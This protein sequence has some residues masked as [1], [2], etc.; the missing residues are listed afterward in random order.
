MTAA[1]TSDGPVRGGVPTLAES[2][3]TLPAHFAAALD[4]RIV[5]IGTGVLEQLGRVLDDLLGYAPATVVVLSD[6]TPY[7]RVDADAQQRGE[8]N[9]ANDAPDVSSVVV[10][11]CA[12][13]GAVREVRL[14]GSGRVHADEV[15]VQH[16]VES[17][18]GAG[19]L[20]SVGSGTVADIGKVVAARHGIPHVIV[21]TATSVNGFADDQSV[22]LVGGAKRTRPSRWPDAVLADLSVLA[23]APTE[24]NLA[25]VGDMLSSLTA[26]ADWLLAS[27]IG[28]GEPYVVELV[29]LVRPHR[30]R[31]L[32]LAA[33]VGSARPED[34][35]DLARLLTLS[36]ASMGLAGCTSP[37]SGTEHVISHL[38]DMRLGAAGL[39]PAW[40]G[41]QVGVATVVASALWQRVRAHL[42]SGA[43]LVV[44][45][46]PVE[47]AQAATYA[48]FGPLDSSGRAADECWE[49]YERKLAWL[50]DN[51]G[52]VVR[53]V[54]D[55][56]ALADGLRRQLLS[57]EELVLA[58]RGTGLPVRLGDLG[59]AYTRDT[60]HWAVA[61]GHRMRDRFTV[62]DLADLLGIWTDDDVH[63]LLDDL[64]RM[65]AGA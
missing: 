25:G 19:A 9:D 24:L 4:L 26:P 29:D 43:P 52:E 16:A 7:A 47:E 37:S 12:A 50:R 42:A 13:R 17:C 8:A 15:T 63:S 21:Q 44:R 38:L 45:V 31:L 11:I 22:L 40:H 41:L 54:R 14:D 3:A 18:R 48:A 28:L 61:N 32:A 57:A 2:L 60:V 62:A 39:T 35:A 23:G 1:T 34:L 58:L 65:G 55:W 49:A 20:V 6:G 36:G 10:S 51:V 33:G 53:V 56:D 5:L 27:T 30:D 46:P 59:P 64:A